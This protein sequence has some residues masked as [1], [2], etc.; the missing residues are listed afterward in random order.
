MLSLQ[1]LSDRLEIEQLI[2]R[3]SN[4]IDQRDWDG[5]DAVFTPDAYIDYR[6]LGG[7]DGR[8]PR[9]KGL[10]RAG[11]RQLSA[12]LSPGGQHRDH[13]RGRYRPRAHPVHQSDGYARCRPADPRSCF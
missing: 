5:L 13:A 6:K 1:E 12:L 2:V 9:G 4:C 10:A 8:F 3:Y 11:A 7:I